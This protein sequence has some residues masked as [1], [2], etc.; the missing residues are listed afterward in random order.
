[1]MGKFTSG[2]STRVNTF[3]LSPGIRNGI[4]LLTEGFTNGNFTV[5]RFHPMGGYSQVTNSVGEI[6]LWDLRARVGIIPNSV[7][8]PGI[9]EQ[10][11]VN[12]N[13]TAGTNVGGYQFEVVYDRTALRYVDSVNGDYLP[14]GAFFLPHVLVGYK[15]PF[16]SVQ[17]GATSLA[18][19]SNGDGTLATLTFEVVDVKR[20]IMYLSNVIFTDSEGE[21]LPFLVGSSKTVVPPAAPLSADIS[22][23]PW[24]KIT[25]GIGEE[26]TFRID[27]TGGEDIKRYSISL[28]YNEAAL[29]YVGFENGNYLDNVSL[30]GGEGINAVTLQ[31][32]S[33]SGSGNGDGTLATVTFKVLEPEPAQTPAVNTSS[34][35]I[36]GA[37]FR[38]GDGL[39]YYHSYHRSYL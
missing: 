35:Y 7:A 24:P 1:M 29:R 18:G 25:A 10:F 39:W 9:G 11:S 16:R 14:A 6:Y 32:T 15:Q 8:S 13:I 19:V 23:T 17:I 28:G 30:W 2:I 3:S 20:S 38:G 4:G 31:A 37:S 34:V 22:I 5:L 21:N 27:I 12:V 26:I 33:L 36:H